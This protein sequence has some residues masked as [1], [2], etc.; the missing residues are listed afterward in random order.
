MKFVC[1][2]SEKALKGDKNMI[3]I[4]K[5]TK[6]ELEEGKE[7]TQ[8]KILDTLSESHM[9]II[10][11]QLKTIFSNNKLHIANAEI[12][13]GNI[14][15]HDWVSKIVTKLKSS[16]ANDSIAQ[17]DG[18]EGLQL[19]KCPFILL[20]NKSNSYKVANYHGAIVWLCYK[21][22][23]RFI[24][25]NR[26]ANCLSEEQLD[27]LEIRGIDT[28]E[29]I[30]DEKFEESTADKYKTF[31]AKS[32]MLGY[33]SNSFSYEIENGDVKLKKYTGTGK[34]IILPSFITAIMADAF[35]EVAIETINLNEGLKVIGNGA[36]EPFKMSDALS[37]IEIPSTVQL[38]G[39]RAFNNNIRL[40]NND[41]T[42]NMYKIK[43]RNS[44]TVM[45]DDYTQ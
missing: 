9:T 33:K 43:L 40:F 3:Y 44:N 14:Q 30:V 21:D 11:N 35:T 15:V 31:I 45:I 26:L 22:L 2:M 29:I 38:I 32:N 36:F 19:E 24:K 34:N 25:L 39:A 5:V 12:V 20:A 18:I 8:Y 42:L 23:K 1:S 16:S 7:L 4:I 27:G 37:T 17:F 13:N 41:G 28:H 6:H 10:T